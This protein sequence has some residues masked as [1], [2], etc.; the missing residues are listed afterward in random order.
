MSRT[1]RPD[2]WQRDL[3]LAKEG[4]AEIAEVL[5]GD[6]RLEGFEDH[7]EEVDRLDFSFEY[8][9]LEVDVDLKEKRQRYSPGV[10]ELW[11]DVLPRDLF[12]VDETVYRRIVWRGGGGYL[13]VHDH[14]E[15][16]WAIFGPWE[17]TLGPRLRYQRWGRRKGGGFLKGKILLD[18][19]AAGFVWP[20]F[21]V[22]DLLWLID[23]STT[24]RDAVEAV[25]TRRQ[26][27]P[28]LGDPP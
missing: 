2:D 22:D 1:R 20:E 23:R 18:L 16:R 5:A 3:L 28:E 21:R 17:L 11:P 24:K 10:A 12:I 26:D 13:I 6:P 4:E 8:R 9:G 25:A 7:T 15:D 14:P 19:S 27:L